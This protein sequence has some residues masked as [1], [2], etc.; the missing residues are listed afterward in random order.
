[1]RSIGFI[2]RFF[3]S[4]FI[5]TALSVLMSLNLQIVSASS[6]GLGYFFNR[7]AKVW[8]ETI[9]LGNGR[10]GLMPEGGIMQEKIVL[11]DITLWSGAPQDADNPEAYASLEQIRQL[12]FAGKNDEAQQLMYSTF[13]CK[14]KGSGQ[15]SGKD[16]PYGSY[17]MLGT[18]MVD[19][20]YGEEIPSA[21]VPQDYRRELDL[22]QATAVSSFT[23]NGVNYRREYLTSFSEDVA[24]IRL[25]ADQ[26]KK[27][28]F[29]L[30]INRPERFEVHTEGDDL[31]MQ[32]TLNDGSGGEGMEYISRARILPKGGKLTNDGKSIGVEGANEALIILSMNTDY[33]NPSFATQNKQL[34]DRA[35]KIAYPNL[36]SAHSSRYSQLFNRVALDLGH[37][38]EREN[39]PIDQRLAAFAQSGNDN[40]LA[41]LYFQYGRYLLICSTR[42]GILPPNLQGLWSNTLQTPWNGDYHLN[43]NLQMNLWPAE[44]TNLSELHLPLIELTK[45]LV[46]PGKKTAKAFYNADGWVAHMM[47]NVWGYTAP[48][49]H[50]SWGAT[51][52]A[53]AWLCQ[54]LWEHYLFIND[55]AYLRSIYPVLKGSAQFFSDMLVAEPKNGWLVTAPTTSPENSFKLP[56]GKTAAIC[57]GS[58]MDNQIVREQFGYVAEAARILKTDQ[59][60]AAELEKLSAKLPPDQI[61][62]HGQ[63]MEWLEDYEETEP[64]HRHTSQLYGLHPGNQI[65]PY[66]TP[67]LAQA[68]RVTLE[69][70][71][72][73]GTGWSRAWKINFWARL[74][75]G[76]RAYKLLTQLLVPVMD[77]GFN[78][79]PQGG[80][81]YPNLFCAH[82]PFQID[83]NFG[84]CAGIA[85]MLVQSHADFIELLPA[86]PDQWAT[87]SF[88]GMKVRGGAVVDAQWEN[89]TLKMIR[90]KAESNN[91]FRIKVSSTDFSAR[92][93][94][95]PLKMSAQSGFV[96]VTMSKEDSLTLE[97]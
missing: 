85:E 69:R 7:P 33:R 60:W 59:H 67:E 32:G 87:G 3:R 17:Q 29:R 9:P 46:E 35:A 14:G 42:P 22:A 19:Y 93:N 30:S 78:Y 75:D 56:N 96:E 61:G 25:T 77:T 71:G 97:W 20:Q 12:L 63:L 80:G 88:S 72:D 13:I 21:D 92:L 27:I 66:G 74:A 45:S 82:P 70:R 65:T 6:S 15:G 31:L 44:V 53:G 89:K 38:P 4:V 81:T 48:G 64:Q 18:L 5:P 50:P 55:T 47:T 91:C 8:E 94:G 39:L 62:K 76:N 2:G 54:H 79:G 95:K 23:F 36:K 43:I 90:L 10:I 26:S 57:I 28:S 84:G 11:N 24:V 16:V 83:G 51:N 41:E 49:E 1:M 37:N 86:L 34:L 52:T 68:A 73:G 58:T 40:G